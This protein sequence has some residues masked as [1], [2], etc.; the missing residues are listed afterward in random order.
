MSKLA[1]SNQDTMDE[2]EQRALFTLDPENRISESEAFEILDAAGIDE[3]KW[4]AGLNNEYMQWIYL[5]IK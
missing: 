4:D 1:H 2:I 5:N 3:I